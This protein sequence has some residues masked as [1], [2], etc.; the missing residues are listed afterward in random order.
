MTTAYDITSP[1]SQYT[2]TF[3]LTSNVSV[4]V[5]KV[6]SSTTYVCRAM[7]GSLTSDPMWQIF[8]VAKSGGITQIRWP[9]NSEGKG[10][11]EFN[12]V[13]DDRATYLYL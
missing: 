8:K 2:R 3:D 5:D 7:P 6:D 12:L 13:A 9:I 4:L 1:D 11:F 10:N